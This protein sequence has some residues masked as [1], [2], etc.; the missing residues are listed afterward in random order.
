MISSLKKLSIDLFKLKDK[1]DLLFVE[2][3][4]NKYLKKNLNSKNNKKLKHVRKCLCGSKIRSHEVRIGLFDYVLCDCGNIYSSPMLDNKQLD[5]IYSNDGAYQIY[6]KKFL[7]NKTKKRIRNKTNQRKTLQV[8]NLLK[9][10]NKSILDIGCGNGDFLKNCKKFGFKQL[11]GVDTK[12]QNIISIKNKIKFTS[13]FKNLK[14]NDQ[15]DCIT[16]W[17]LLEH[18]NNPINYSKNIVKKLKKGGFLVF[19]VPFSESIIMNY[20]LKTK[21]PVLRYLEPGRH[22]HFFSKTFFKI[23]AKKLNLKMYD[24][25]TNGLDVQTILGKQNKNL[26]KKILLIQN[27]LDDL[28]VADHARVVFKK[29]T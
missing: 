12:Y 17:G 13:S 15:F 29:V 14:K 2:K 6:R 1:K 4:F 8:F 10:K 28:G 9:K 25:E 23:L 16:L 27:I 19:E 24:F 5:Q 22:L 3:H 20:I 21:K 18:I 7:E 11:Y 26:T